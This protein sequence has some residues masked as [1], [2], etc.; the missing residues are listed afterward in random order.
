MESGHRHSTRRVGRFGIVTYWVD[1]PSSNRRP[2]G[3]RVR[4]G[5]LVGS[6][7]CSR[8]DAHHDPERKARAR[9]DHHGRREGH[10]E[11]WAQIRIKLV[12]EPRRASFVRYLSESRICPTEFPSP[13]RRPHRMTTD[14][15][16]Y[17]RCL[18]SPDSKTVLGEQHRARCLV[19]LEQGLHDSLQVIDL[20]RRREAVSERGCVRLRRRS[21]TSVL[22][23]AR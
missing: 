23:H 13:V 1:H 8:M 9:V 18:S 22:L 14:S 21:C 16:V 11:A 5:G 6:S 10:P 7:R 17:A 19:Q 3:A 2:G 20:R 15:P 12:S 4:E